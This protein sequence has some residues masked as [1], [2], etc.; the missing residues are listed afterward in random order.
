MKLSETF[1]RNIWTKALE[2]L[3]SQ[4]VAKVVAEKAARR[5]FHADGEPGSGTHCIID[6]QLGSSP[7]TGSRSFPEHGERAKVKYQI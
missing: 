2:I 4:I 6:A 1:I 7:R 5:V 3:I